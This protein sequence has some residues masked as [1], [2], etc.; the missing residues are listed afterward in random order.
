[1]N[2]RKNKPKFIRADANRHVRIKKK[3]HKPKGMHSRIAK[4]NRGYRKMPGKGYFADK[5][6]KYLHPSKFMVIEVSN[7]NELAGINAKTHAV[8]IKRV[9]MKKKVEILKKALEMKLYVLNPKDIK[10]YI[11]DAEEAMKSRKE[12]RKSYKESKES[13]KKKQQEKK[14]EAEKKQETA[15]EKKEEIKKVEKEIQQSSQVKKRTK[16]GEK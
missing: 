5:T 1:M 4:K 9:G 2:T 3:W 6:T 10:K 8:K 15:E 16:K 7:I 13:K 12:K 14:K 11:A